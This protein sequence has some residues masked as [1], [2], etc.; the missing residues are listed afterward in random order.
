MINITITFKPCYFGF[1]A[2]CGHIY[3]SSGGHCYIGEREKKKDSKFLSRSSKESRQIVLR[4]PLGSYVLLFKIINADIHSTEGGRA[5]ISSIRGS[6]MASYFTL[7][8]FNTGTIIV[9]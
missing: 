5:I 1:S 3:S 2:L 8:M 4:F 9:T 7:K 6:G